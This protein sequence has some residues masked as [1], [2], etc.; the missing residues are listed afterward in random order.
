[1]VDP[2]TRQKFVDNTISTVT[3]NFMD[4]VNFDHEQIMDKSDRQG[5]EAFT[6]TVKA[7]SDKLKAISPHYQV[8]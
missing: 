4:G 5:Q 8:R 1:M 7:V 2:D 6:A 3:N